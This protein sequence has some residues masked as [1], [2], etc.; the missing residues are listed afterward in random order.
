MDALMGLGPVQLLDGDTLEIE[1][2][3]MVLHAEGLWVP[4]DLPAELEEKLGEM[5]FL[6]SVGLRRD[7]DEITLLLSNAERLA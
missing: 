1:G 4:D 7:G 3:K 6:V 5:R 2:L